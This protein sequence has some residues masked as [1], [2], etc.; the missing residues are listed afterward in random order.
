[1]YI[2]MTLN[3]NCKLRGFR[4]VIGIIIAAVGSVLSGCDDFL[5][6]EVKGNN[7]S[8]K[9]YDTRYK[10]QASL[11]AAY[12]ILQSNAMQDTD[13][14]FGE[15]IG[16]NVIGRDEGLS[17]HMGQLAHFRFNT[18]NNFI[19][20][21]W[22]IYY[23]GIH[24]V[25]QVIAN[26][27]KARLSTDDYKSYK[28]IREILGQAK[29]LRAYFYFNLARTFGGVPIRPEVEE[30]EKIVIPRSSL[31]E[32]YAYIEKD[33]R[34]AAIMLPNRYTSN[35]SGKASSGA[36]T[37]LLMK[38]LMYQA[39]PGIPSEKWEEMTR[40]GDYFVKGASFS[41]KDMLHYPDNYEGEDWESLRKRLWFK[42]Q[43]LNKETDPYETPENECP[44]L[45]NAYSLRYIDAYGGAITYD[46]QFYLQGEFC[47]GSIFEI[48]FKE[49]GDGSVD[50]N[51]EGNAIFMNMFPQTYDDANSSHI[52]IYCDDAVLSKI[53]FSGSNASDARKR[54]ILGHHENTPDME[55]TEIGAGRVLPLKWYTPV[56]DRPV[57]AG[58]NGKNRRILRYVDVVLMYAEALNECGKGAEA[59]EQLN[60]NKRVVNE[61]N[62]SSTLY[63][64][65]GY[66]YLRQQIW[67]ERTIE[68][69]FEWE[70]FF[71]IVRQGRAKECLKIFSDLR[72]NRR[73]A[74]FKEGIN[75]IFPIPQ[76][77]I[78]LSNG[79]VT[80]NPGY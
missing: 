4:L 12:D 27:D 77:E 79:V 72:S 71:D 46:Q 20:N 29:F 14:R 48:V 51:N 25:N 31:E 36:A 39:K 22:N 80:Q 8:E 7:T 50:D 41:F 54:Y 35:N 44:V 34:E 3:N 49:S 16:D 9:F 63:I 6:Q 45:L 60:S 52:P 2:I 61:I 62:N 1:M 58:D 21:R 11:N 57:Y 73:G 76:R 75:E 42:P 28:E 5:E 33:L 74:Y 56:K 37:A 17:G 10:L 70:R 78:D 13:W 18:S 15:A 40:L 59:L 69:C 66:G 68:L 53:I 38:V 32:T 19:L 47:Q 24:R 64:G 23:K 26:I 30:V 43:E 67:D 65:G 55:N